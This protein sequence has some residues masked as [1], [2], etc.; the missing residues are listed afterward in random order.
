MRARNIVLLILVWFA[1][2][3]LFVIINFGGQILFSPTHINGQVKA[4]A[5][6]IQHL[7]YFGGFVVT[8]L[9]GALLCR[10]V[11]SAVPLK[12]CLGLGVLFVGTYLVPFFL[13]LPPTAYA[14]T[15]A[16]VWL[17]SVA[18]ALGYALIPVLGGYL[19]KRRNLHSQ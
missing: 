17:F 15:S 13:F 5:S 14:K 2:F 1:A 10:F 7:H 3:G 9:A 4:S 19:V 11:D 6:T 18:E 12:W 16:S 8:A